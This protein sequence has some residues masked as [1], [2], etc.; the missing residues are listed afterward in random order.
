MFLT[1]A[2]QDYIRTLKDVNSDRQ[3]QHL[4]FFYNKVGKIYS[5]IRFT[6]KK[7]LQASERANKDGTI[8][9]STSKKLKYH[10]CWSCNPPSQ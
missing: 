10:C 8:M 7:K 3:P 5:N 9:K 6:D 4:I 1:W 2:D